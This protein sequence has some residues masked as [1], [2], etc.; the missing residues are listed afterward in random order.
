MPG[1]FLPT[2]VITPIP[3]NRPILTN[4]VPT[5]LNPV[6]ALSSLLKGA[7]GR[8]YK[9]K[10]KKLADKLHDKVNSKIKSKS[11]QGMLHKAICTVTGHPVDV[12]SGTFFTDEEDFWLDGP[13]PLSWERTWYSRSEYRGPLGNGWHHAYDMGVVADREDGTLTLRM[14]DG[15][16]VAFPLPSEGHPSFI[17]AERKEARREDGQWIVWDL[18]EDLHYR[19]TRET[20]D[21]VHL[22]ES[23]TDRNGLGITFRYDSRGCM[24]SLTDSAGRHIGVENDAEGRITRITG[25]SP[26]HGGEPVELARYAYD[27]DGN[28]ISETNAVG[29]T[30]SYGYEG[31]LIV[32]EIW[33]NGLEWFF[34][35]DGEHP[36]ARCVHTWGTGGIYDHRLTYLDGV[37]EVLDSHDELTVYRHRRGLV[38]RK[39][40]A[41][42]GEHRWRYD[43]DRQLLETISPTGDS[44]LYSYDRWGNLTGSSDPCGGSVAAAY[45]RKGPDCNL[46]LTVTTPDGG[47]WEFRYDSRG[48]LTGRVNPMGAVTQIAY[49]DG[50]VSAVTDPYGTET[51]LTYDG[52]RNLTEA[53]DSRG[54][55]TRFRYDRLGR[56]VRM[57][58][59]RGAEQRRE[60]DAIGRVVRVLD[61]DGNDIRLTY[62]G[63]DNLTEYRD[64]LQRIEYG[65]SGM[66]KLT[67]RRDHRGVVLFRYDREERLRRVVNERRESYEF[68][69]D[70]V[71]GVIAEKG[72]D[73]AVRRY[74]RDLGEESS[75][76][77]SPAAQNGSTPTTAARA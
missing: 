60:Y 61:F 56:C 3:W 47:T 37:T 29:D 68:T 57:T 65:Y 17:L 73:G 22:L 38:W 4:P 46:P 31:R 76:R 70:A 77:R 9:R 74:V 16:P 52:D 48:N 28:M 66:W 34:E 54:N 13:V 51:R 19:F 35:Y 11:L 24:E 71:G 62:D 12:A 44:T 18:A 49:R 6:T 72:F 26:E 59:P 10:T 45:P 14:N 21:S 39:T 32:K 23:V 64:S 40:D 25:P 41:N 63:I 58:N 1:L 15:I 42:G 55:V 2:G 20:Y 27:P 69:L 67:R 30:M 75:G 8:F 7:F 43:D 5:P 50:L 53:H 33:R 36:G